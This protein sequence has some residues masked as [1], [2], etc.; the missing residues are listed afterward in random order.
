MEFNFP[1]VV[2]ML[3]TFFNLARANLYGL[4]EYKCLSRISKLKHH[5]IHDLCS[6]LRSTCILII[7]ML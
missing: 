6:T 5:T 2:P 3:C 1:H 7:I 4:Q